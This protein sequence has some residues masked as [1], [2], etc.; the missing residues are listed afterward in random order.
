MRAASKAVS[1]YR[2]PGAT[3][4][5]TV[6]PCAMC[7]GALVWA[8]VG[9][10]VYGTRDSKAGAV[11]SL[12]EICTTDTL[13]HRID[14]REGVLEGDCRVLMQ[15]FFVRGGHARARERRGS[16]I[17]KAPVSKTGAGNR[18]GVRVPLPP[19]YASSGLRRS[20][21]VAKGATLETSCTGNCTVGSNPTSSVRFIGVGLRATTACKPRQGREAATVADTVVCRGL[22]GAR[23]A[24]ARGCFIPESLSFLIHVGRNA[25]GRSD[26]RGFFEEAARSERFG[27]PRARRRPPAPPVRQQFREIGGRPFEHAGE[28]SGLRDAVVRSPAIER[29]RTVP[30]D[31]RQ[32]DLKSRRYESS[33]LPSD[34]RPHHHERLSRNGQTWNE[35]L[36][37]E[38]RCEELFADGAGEKGFCPDALGLR[39][40]CFDGA[41]RSVSSGG[42]VAEIG[43]EPG[44]L[45]RLGRRICPYET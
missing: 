28:R 22:S 40:C 27:N 43:L 13:N 23:P 2:L 16:L 11:H 4:Y 20:V 36:A 45:G 6:E 29:G 33:G 14:V 24:G 17:G 42:I 21:R 38:P 9:R 30:Y 32:A 8:R 7:A 35:L 10:L 12:F 5:V 34:D 37:V 15:E 26:E 41:A 39:S 18:L 44:E 19:P 31:E 25:L 3:V 1:N